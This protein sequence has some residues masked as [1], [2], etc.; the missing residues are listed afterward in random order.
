MC[1]PCSFPGGVSRTVHFSVL[2]PGGR[3]EK[4][5][6]MYVI[7]LLIGVVFIC[8]LSLKRASSG[9]TQG[10]SLLLDT[11]WLSCVDSGSVL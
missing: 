9:G 5:G 8:H 3:E 7:L 11:L 1:L 2:T 6:K 10:C 4:K